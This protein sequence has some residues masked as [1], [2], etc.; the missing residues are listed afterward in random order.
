MVNED[1]GSVQVCAVIKCGCIRRD[2]EVELNILPNNAQCRLCLYETSITA[3]VIT[4]IEEKT[5]KCKLV[6]P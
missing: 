1:V 5:L 4:L 3:M 2:V 6:L